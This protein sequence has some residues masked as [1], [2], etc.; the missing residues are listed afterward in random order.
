MSDVVAVA[1]ITGSATVLTSAI[2]AAV[3]WRVS[4]HGSDIELRKVEAENDRL[5]QEHKESA[6][7]S[8]QTTYRD[9]IAAYNQ[10]DNLSLL[11]DPS[12]EEIMSATRFLIQKRAEIQLVAPSG[13]VDR[14]PPMFDQFNAIW[15][16]ALG[17]DESRSFGCRW[18]AEFVAVRSEVR[19][20][21][22]AII[23]A[24]KKDLALV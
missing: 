12:E 9:F 14:L 19:E 16:D 22:R 7:Q 15:N 5:R 1:A 11:V 2:T 4:R 24:M 21:Q 3:T 18:A 20:K 6:R 10:F 17:G 13:V 8:R 23:A